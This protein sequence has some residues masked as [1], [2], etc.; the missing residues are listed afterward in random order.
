MLRCFSWVLFF[1]A[2]WTK[3]CQASL[4]MEFSRHEYWS[5]LPCPPPGDLPDPNPCLLLCLLHWQVGSLPLVPPEKQSV[6]RP[7]GLT[8]CNPVDR[9]LP[10]SSIHGILQARI[11]N[12]VAILFSRG[13]F[14]N[15]GIKPGSPALQ[16]NS[17]SSEQLQKPN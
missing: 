13:I 9:S 14:P 16:Q 11:L 4:S 3:A 7:W 8:L 10:D 12:W 17:L 2:L 15:P 1:V 5:G 6:S